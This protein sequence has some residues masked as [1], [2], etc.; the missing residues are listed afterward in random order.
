MLSHLCWSWV[1]LLL[2]FVVRWLWAELH[3]F[4]TPKNTADREHGRR[5][6][7]KISGPPGAQCSGSLPSTSREILTAPPLGQTSQ[8]MIT[9]RWPREAARGS[10][11]THLWWR[12]HQDRMEPELAINSSS[13]SATTSDW[14][15]ADSLP[16]FFYTGFTEAPP[17]A[18]T[19]GSWRQHQELVPSKTGISQWSQILSPSLRD[20]I[21]NNSSTSDL[22]MKNSFPVP[23]TPFQSHCHHPSQVLKT[24][25]S[26][27]L[28]TVNTQHLTHPFL[29]LIRGMILKPHHPVPVFKQ[30]PHKLF[31]SFKTKLWW[32]HSPSLRSQMY[33]P[34]P[35]QP[36]LKAYDPAVQIQ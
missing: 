1:L 31:S 28:L 36:Q 13:V 7:W 6:I 4:P 15:K 17:I 30:T 25:N 33:L 19:P 3:Y 23:V 34:P 26:N 14:N 32:K 29:T 35:T 10:P 5:A 8:V 22:H 9:C 2:A 18:Q 11:F 24:S 21:N 16:V 20:L 12:N 27:S